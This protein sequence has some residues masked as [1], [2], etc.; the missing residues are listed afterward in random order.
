MPVFSIIVMTIRTKWVSINDE[1]DVYQKY[2]EG[3]S[4]Y[5]SSTAAIMDL[6]GWVFQAL[7]N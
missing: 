4:V 1:G 5:K 6:A 3:Y 2:E 7:A